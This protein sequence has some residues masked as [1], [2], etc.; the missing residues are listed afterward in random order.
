MDRRLNHFVGRLFSLGVAMV[1]LGT[2][3]IC[4]SFA[5]MSGV[6]SVASGAIL[7]DTFY[8]AERLR[9]KLESRL[10]C[11][12]ER[13]AAEGEPAACDPSCCAPFHLRGLLIAQLFF[14]SFEIIVWITF[15]ALF[16]SGFQ[17]YTESYSFPGGGG[18]RTVCPFN[19]SMAADSWILSYV[20]LGI[21]F[22][23]TEL[24]LG[25]VAL[26]FFQQASR[27]AR[28]NDATE[29]R[30]PTGTDAAVASEWGA[31]DGNGSYKAAPAPYGYGP[32]ASAPQ[33][34]TLN[35]KTYH[36]MP[37]T[38]PCVAGS[39]LLLPV[40]K[41]DMAVASANPPLPPAGYYTLPSPAAAPAASK[42]YDQPPPQPP[43]SG[44]AASGGPLD[45]PARSPP[46]Q[47]QAFAPPPSQQPQQEPASDS[48]GQTAV[49]FRVRNPLSNANGGGN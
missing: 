13:R 6:L 42:S 40:S 28:L 33:M 14:A 44:A 45:W 9:G 36:A 41:R 12:G 3:A 18:T 1:V 21:F 38:F 11:C 2:L 5:F 39:L 49:D 10:G 43:H 20:I 4:F 22:A 16:G 35:D 32:S 37:P 46:Q 17:C 34:V 8:S 25:G 15:S 47:Q 24:V 31:A 30:G 27:Y 29:F 48:R 7:V 26:S 19:I 23:A